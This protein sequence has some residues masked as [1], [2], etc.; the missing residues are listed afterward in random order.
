MNGRF[1][2]TAAIRKS[3]EMEMSA[4]HPTADIRRLRHHVRKEQATSITDGGS[5]SG[6]RKLK[7]W[8]FSDSLR[9]VMSS[10]MRCRSG[11]MAL[12][13]MGDAPV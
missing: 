9:I 2:P 6:D 12:S 11:L 3:D 10:I 4:S 7:S 1:A 8:V 13:V 5:V